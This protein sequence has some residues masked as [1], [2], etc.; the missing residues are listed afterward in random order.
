MPRPPRLFIPNGIYHVASRGSD[1]RPLFLHDD[2]R[3]VFLA[4]LSQA[5]ERY[6]FSCV[7]YHHRVRNSSQKEALRRLAALGGTILCPRSPPYCQYGDSLCPCLA[8][9]DHTQPTVIHFEMSSRHFFKQSSP[10]SPA[11]PGRRRDHRR[12][13]QHLGRADNRQELALVQAC[14]MRRW[15]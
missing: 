15:G 1:R 8:L 4:R 6:E 3:E 5:V 10:H 9:A 14:I 11:P 13:L 12:G 7:A 2:D